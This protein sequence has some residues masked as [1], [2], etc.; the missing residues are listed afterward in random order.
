M[1]KENLFKLIARGE[2]VLWVGSGM[3]LYAGL[4]SGNQLASFLFDDLSEEEKNI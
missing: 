2:V 4:P 3:S 1:Y